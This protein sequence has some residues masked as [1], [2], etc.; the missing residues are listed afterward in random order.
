MGFTVEAHAALGEQGNNF[1]ELWGCAMVFQLVMEYGQ[2]G[3]KL[4]LCSDSTNSINIITYR[5][6]PKITAELGHACRSLANAANDTNPT[7]ANWVAGHAD[8]PLNDHVDH[9]AKSAARRSRAGHPLVDIER[10]IQEKDFVPPQCH[11]TFHLTNYF[12][13]D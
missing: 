6:A 8:I 12:A 5:A 7:T 9:L 10:R 2:P 1:A 13:G 11:R 3:T 4:I